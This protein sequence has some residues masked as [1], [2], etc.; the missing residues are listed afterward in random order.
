M[1][2]FRGLGLIVPLAGLLLAS[3][4]PAEEHRIRKAVT[5]YASFDDSAEADYSGGER[6]LSTR[7]NHP[8]AKGTFVIT[9][10]YDATIFPV[11]KGKGIHGGAL[12]PTDVLSQNG[13]IFYPAQGNLAFRKGGWGGAVSCW[14]NTDPNK[15]LKTKFCDPV[16][17][18]QKGANHGGIWFDF[19]DAKPRDLRMGMFPAV[20]VG[21]KGITEA[22]PRAPMVPVKG[23]A[24][25][26]GEWHHVVLTW[27]NFDTGKPNAHAVLYLDGKPRGEIKDRPLAMDWEIEKAGIYV[28]INYLGLL[29]EFAV[30]NRALTAAEVGELHQRPGLLAPLKKGK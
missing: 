26:E 25:K 24:F 18:T 2:T 5:L 16:Q 28:A 13:R 8:T 19:N 22:D 10:G 12:R 30:F 29:D 6:T 4:L 3:P 20:P 11:A 9:K 7:L 14:V 21:E 1:S 15:L 27:D 17:I 23:V